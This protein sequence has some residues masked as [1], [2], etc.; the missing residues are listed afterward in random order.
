MPG[1][2]LPA[3]AATKS[4]DRAAAALHAFECLSSERVVRIKDDTWKLTGKVAVEQREKGFTSSSTQNTC[5]A[6]IHL[7]GPCDVRHAMCAVQDAIKDDIDDG[8]IT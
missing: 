8:G 3:S 6:S 4:R 5:A 2:E 7:R 1:V